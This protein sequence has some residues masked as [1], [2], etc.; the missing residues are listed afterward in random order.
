MLKTK[1]EL[2][3]HLYQKCKEIAFDNTVINSVAEE[4]NQ[5]YNV[6]TGLATDMIV[7]REKLENFT[8]YMLFVLLDGFE[9]SLT[10]THSR[11]IIIAVEQMFAFLKER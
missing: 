3:N 9:V 11:Y 2:C 6:P 4:I 5:K 1:Q 7:G 10:N 8:E